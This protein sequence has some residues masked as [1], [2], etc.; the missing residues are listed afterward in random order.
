MHYVSQRR[1]GRMTSAEPATSSPRAALCSSQ[2][3]HM[4]VRLLAVLPVLL[5]VSLMSGEARQ[6]AGAPETYTANL[7]AVGAQGGA[8]TA[9]IQIDIRRYTPEA[10]RTAVQA[11]LTS[12]GYAAF[13]T[14][15]HKAP[16]V[17]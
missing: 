7:E 1:A 4:S 6:Q 3:L 13:L 16:E 8:V 9:T 17:G 5:I 11:A 10:E 12:G 15:L 2:E 14:A